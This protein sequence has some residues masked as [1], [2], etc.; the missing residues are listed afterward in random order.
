MPSLSKQPI[1]TLKSHCLMIALVLG[2]SGCASL[3]ET[4]NGPSLTPMA[5]PQTLVPSKP[6]IL[7]APAQN[8]PASS[9][10]LWR[11]G[12]RAFFNDQRARQVGDILTV[13]VAIDDAAQTQNATSG[14]RS[15]DYDA[16]TP[17]ILG[18]EST[19]GKILPGG[20]NPERALGSTSSANQSGSGTIKRSEQINL[21]IA[22]VVTGVL[23]NGNLI[24][25]GTQ[26]V[27]T[28][29]EV[30][31]LSVSGIAR[32][33]DITATN[34]IKHDQ[35]AEA[36]IHYGGKGDITN[37][38]SPPAAQALMQKYSPF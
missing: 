22:A 35:L 15:S 37:M 26:E 34:T 31:I 3:K 27:R 29:R 7:T 23:P 9:N 1:L 11:T 6:E 33:E 36:R 4:V 20:Y 8:A 12:A 32:P 16:A 13:V 19:L 25:Q 24:L 21:T 2:T 14:S 28:N 18:L 17:A 30:R 38:N 5:Y 10:S